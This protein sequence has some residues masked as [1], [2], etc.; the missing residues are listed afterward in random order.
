MIRWLAYKLGITKACPECETLVD[1]AL[2]GLETKDSERVRKH[3]SGCPPCLEQVRD[4]LQ[5]NEGLGLTAPETEPPMGFEARI[6]KRCR[7]EGPVPI[8]S[9]Q[10]NLEGWPLFWM[11]LGPVFAGLSVLMTMVTLAVLMGKSGGQQP[12]HEWLQASQALLNDP[13]ATKVSLVGLDP[14]RESSGELVVCRGRRFAALKASHMSRC[15][16]GRNYVLWMKPEGG[17][18]GAQRL[19]R[20]TVE[21]DGSS[22]QWL[23][24]PQPLQGEGP[25]TFTV[26]Q[27]VWGPEKGPLDTKPWLAGSTRL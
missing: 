26:T 9:L 6:L 7:E 1:F 18:A 17:K 25:V 4:F 11:R 14:S 20:F 16:M 21:A 2:E 19:S 22:L 27:E 5:V 8:I 12:S 3:L 13:H 15:A 24:L 10:R 23:E